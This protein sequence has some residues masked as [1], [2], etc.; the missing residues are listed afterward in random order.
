MAEPDA[1]RAAVIGL[2]QADMGAAFWAR[3]R[4]PE[5]HNKLLKNKRI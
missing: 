1:R 5:P 3:K 2:R 4:F